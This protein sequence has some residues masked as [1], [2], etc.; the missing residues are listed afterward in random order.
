M[1]RRTTISLPVHLKEVMDRHRNEYNWSE[2]AARAFAEVLKI[3]LPMSLEER[4][5]R[6]EMML[7]IK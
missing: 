1:I 6:I 2:I 4:V 7:R 5:K 3:K